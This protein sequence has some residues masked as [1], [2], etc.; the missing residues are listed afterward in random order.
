[1]PRMPLEGIHGSLWVRTAEPDPRDALADDI[2]ADVAIVGAGIVGVTAA[3]LLAKEGVSVVVLERDRILRGVTGHTTAKVTSQHNVIYDTLRGRFG[4]E[5][6]RRHADASQAAIATIDRL[7]RETGADAKVVRAPNYVFTTKD[8]SVEALRKE[9]ETAAGLGLPASFT[10]ETEL[11]FRVAGAVRFED[12]MHF[13]PV[14]YLAKLAEAAE[15]RGCRIFERTPVLDIDDGEPA[16]VTAEGGTVRAKHVLVATNVPVTDKAFYVTRML[17]KREYAIAARMG[18]TR[19]QGMYVSY[20]K[21]SP[22]RSVRPY[23]GDDG[24]MLVFAGETHLVGEREPEDHYERLSS[25]AR[26]TLGTGPI[27]Y[28]WSTQDHYPVDDLPLIGKLTP[29]AKRV[30][31][32]TG[33][34]AWGMTQGTVAA[35]MFTDLVQGRE[36]ALWDVYDPFKP[37]RI[38]KD[39]TSPKFFQGQGNAVSELIGERLKRHPAG[40]LAV[41]EGQVARIDGRI[42]AMSKAED[43]SVRMLSATC[44]HMGCVVAYNSLEKSFD[45]R[46]HGSRFAL[47]GTVLHGPAVDPLKAVDASGKE[48]SREGRGQSQ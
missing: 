19:I 36:N 18:E 25:F 26:E 46:C 9:A 15:S 13:H 30:Y 38:A 2:R 3:Y 22:R 43:G 4:E 20:E 33:F 35:G 48:V 17:A 21:D 1:M 31:T 42:V 37:G 10:T 34:R 39:L 11:P 41:G 44:T 12:Q 45:C 24:P 29:G 8:G 7:A 27:L 5:T 32:A 47:D 14:R 40:A 23:A 28:R 16:E 6:A